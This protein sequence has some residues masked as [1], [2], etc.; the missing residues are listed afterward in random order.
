MMFSVISMTVISTV[1]RVL[2]SNRC[3]T[4]VDLKG[5]SG[6]TNRTSDAHESLAF[7]FVSE[8]EC[9]CVCNCAC[10]CDLEL[11]YLGLNYIHSFAL[12]FQHSSDWARTYIFPATASQSATVLC[13]HTQLN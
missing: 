13:H 2:L 10:V 11:R 12:Y 4:F 8:R 3:F 1:V 6:P 7:K 9:V 5:A